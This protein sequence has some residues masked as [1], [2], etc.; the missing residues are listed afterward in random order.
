MSKEYKYVGPT[1]NISTSDAR[2]PGCGGSGM[3]QQLGS[4]P[5]RCSVCGGSGTIPGL[6]KQI[7]DAAEDGWE[8]VTHTLVGHPPTKHMVILGREKAAAA[9]TASAKT[10]AAN[11]LKAAAGKS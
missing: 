6:L 8:V 9:P 5:D 4:V 10:A 7:N 2:C 3:R 1:E 11:P